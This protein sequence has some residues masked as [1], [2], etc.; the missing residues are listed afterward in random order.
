MLPSDLALVWDKGAARNP[1]QSADPFVSGVVHV[2]DGVSIAYTRYD[3][4]KQTPVITFRPLK[5]ISPGV[6][7]CWGG[8]S[9]GAHSLH[10]RQVSCI[11][12]VPPRNV[13]TP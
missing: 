1:S 9:C 8:L 7:C 5:K 4:R 10:P 6:I 13:I 12:L 3:R 2:I 11:G